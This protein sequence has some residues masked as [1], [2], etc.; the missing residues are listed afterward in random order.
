MAGDI[1]TNYFIDDDLGAPTS[2]EIARRIVNTL[3]LNTRPIK[4]HND[5]DSINDCWEELLYH[6]E[7]LEDRK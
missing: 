7:V 1:T 6:I 4:G 5:P 3:R 2:Y